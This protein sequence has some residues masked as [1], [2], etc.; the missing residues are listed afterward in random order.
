MNIK[1]IPETKIIYR[2]RIGAYGMENKNLMEDFKRWLK[3]NEL[4]NNESIILAIPRD[5]P[6]TTNPENCRYDVA[7]IVDSLD[8]IQQLDIKKG[9][10]KSSK[11]AIFSVIHTEQ[12]IIQ[13]MQNML[14]EIE[15]KG[16]SFDTQH[17]MIERYAVKMVENN[18][19][20]ICIPIL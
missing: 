4:L 14:P 17:P 18:L 20:E 3:N 10:L 5:N 13:A 16:Y 2:R 7:L 11:Y 6:Q 8:T 12:A 19:C 15:S 1:I 9:V